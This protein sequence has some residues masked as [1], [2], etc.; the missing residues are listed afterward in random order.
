MST[1]IWPLQDGTIIIGPDASRTADVAETPRE[2]AEVEYLTGERTTASFV[3]PA[4]AESV[5]VLGVQFLPPRQGGDDQAALCPW[6]NSRC[7]VPM[8]EL[9][10][11]L[12]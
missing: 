11:R 6:Q 8:A 2:T 5:W 12:L 10:R 4:P 1:N 9:T 7:S 3:A